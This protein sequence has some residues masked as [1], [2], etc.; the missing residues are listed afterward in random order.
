MQLLGARVCAQSRTLRRI[1]TE[2]NIGGVVALNTDGHSIPAS[3]EMPKGS[4]IFAYGPTSLRVG[5]DGEDKSG[6]RESL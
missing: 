1:A 4:T 2:R 6:R 5:I 3:I